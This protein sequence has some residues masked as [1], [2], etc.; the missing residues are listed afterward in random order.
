MG[1]SIPTPATPGAARPGM[2]PDNLFL[3]PAPRALIAEFFGIWKGDDVPRGWRRA[4]HRP[5]A[6]VAKAMASE[7]ARVRGFFY[8]FVPEA[9]GALAPGVCFF[10]LACTVPK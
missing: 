4:R 9:G 3:L 5:A 2:N 1:T 10:T 8:L 6:P 7:P